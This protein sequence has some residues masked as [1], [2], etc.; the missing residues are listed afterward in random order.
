MRIGSVLGQ[1]A[2]HVAAVGLQAILVAAILATLALALSAVY[3]PAGFIAGV[4]DAHAGRSTAASIDLAGSSA[5]RS[6]GP[7]LGAKV[8]FD[9]AYPKTVKNP[10][11][12]VLCYQDGELV[13]GEAGGVTAEFV[14]GGSGSMWVDL[15]GAAD[16]RANL[17]YF[18]WK[19][20][21][22]TYVRLATT[23]FGAGG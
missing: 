18:G 3:K 20:G 16:C 1:S 11:I 9:T 14:L 17:F 23:T 4:D 2:R 15:G 21:A 8:W 5:A 7:A 22:Q 13:Y 12:E 10:R 6:S 19:G